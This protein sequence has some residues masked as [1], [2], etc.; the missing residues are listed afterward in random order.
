VLRQVLYRPYRDDRPVI[1]PDIAAELRL[2][3]QDEVRRLDALL[4][5]PV[6]QQWGYSTPAEPATSA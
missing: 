1:D 2:H 5:R 3:F 4:D 6:A